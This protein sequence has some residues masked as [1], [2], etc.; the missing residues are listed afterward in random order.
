MPIRHR[1]ATTT[2]IYAISGGIAMRNTLF[3]LGGMAA[4]LVMASAAQAQQPLKIGVILPYSGQLADPSAQLDNGIKLYMK[5]HG[6]TVAGRKIEIIR[7]DTGGIAPDVAKRLAQELIVRDGVDILAGMMATPNALAASDVAEQAKK[8]MVI[9]NAATSIITTKTQYSVRVS[10]TIPQVTDSLGSWAYKNGV[11]KVYTMVSDYGPGH[12]AEDAFSRAFKAAGGEIIG[13]VRMPVSNPDFTAFVQR[14]KDLNPEAIMVFV[15]SGV[16]P[17]A[18]GKSFADRGLDATK[19]KILG[20]GEVTDESAVKSMG[21]AA[22][23]IITAWHYDYNLQSKFNQDFVKAYNE[24]APG[25]KPSFT[26]AGGYDGMHVIYEALKKTGG[27]T[28]A[29]ELVAEA[30]G[31]KWDSPRGPMS[32]DPETRDVVQTIYIRKVEKVGGN[33]VNVDFDK[34][35]NV[36]DPVKARMGK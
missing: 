15:P 16:Q 21:E 35:E 19:I 31:M 5:Q 22:L 10:M 3:R 20:T 23:G 28:D 14:A 26:S 32:I 7:R 6:D 2:T 36:K 29:A 8:F 34:V 33:L 1:I 25:P 11:R 24:L 12:D 30:K 27:K 18:L 17:A 9:M 4:A 13:S